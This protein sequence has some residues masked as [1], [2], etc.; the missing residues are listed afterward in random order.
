MRESRVAV[1]VVGARVPLLVL[2]WL[3]PEIQPEQKPLKP[4]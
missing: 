2:V 3:S 1:L 4:L